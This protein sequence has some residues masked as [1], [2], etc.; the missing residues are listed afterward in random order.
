MSL[1]KKEI[2][3]V[4]RSLTREFGKVA[5]FGYQKTANGAYKLAVDEAP[6]DKKKDIF[7]SA[8]KALGRPLKRDEIVYSGSR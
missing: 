6:E 4:V 2:T 3:K 5:M 7:V 8:G 1:T